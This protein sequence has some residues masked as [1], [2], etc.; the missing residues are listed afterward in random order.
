MT[1]QEF[2]DELKDLNVCFYNRTEKKS[3]Y[4]DKIVSFHCANKK[5]I[6]ENS[7]IYSKHAIGGVSGGSCWES[8]NPQP[9]YSD[10][11]DPELSTELDLIF[12]SICPNISYLC[13]RKVESKIKSDEEIDYEYYGNRT[14]YRIHY[15]SIRDLYDT[16]MEFK[17]LS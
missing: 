12:E 17:A 1:I 6:D 16:L 7:F 10:E 3:R 4:G 14:D 2:I 15:L 9:Y 11:P 13:Y 5:E 8:S